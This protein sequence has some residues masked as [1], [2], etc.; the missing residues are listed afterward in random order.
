MTAFARLVMDLGPE[1][2]RNKQSQYQTPPYQ[3][4]VQHGNPQGPSANRHFGHHAPIDHLSPYIF[5]IPS[6]SQ[7]W[8]AGHVPISTCFF[9]SEVILIDS[10]IPPYPHDIPLD[11]YFFWLNPDKRGIGLITNHSHIISQII[12]QSVYYVLSVFFDVHARTDAR[13]THLPLNA[14]AM[15]C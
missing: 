9:S 11:H 3:S 12:L 7:A 5:H 13:K 14:L 1:K 8:L 15:R 4:T 6:G 10:D 2:I